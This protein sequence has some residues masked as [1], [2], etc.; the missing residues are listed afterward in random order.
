MHIWVKEENEKN[1]CEHGRDSRE[2]DSVTLLLMFQ[3]TSTCQA[4]QQF[5]GLS[6]IVIKLMMT[7]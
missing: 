1:T 5:S 2:F 6:L 3:M 4:G 7:V